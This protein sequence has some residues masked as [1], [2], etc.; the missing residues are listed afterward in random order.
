MEGEIRGCVR[1][2]ALDGNGTAEV[3]HATLADEA[4]GAGEYPC[5]GIEQYHPIERSRVEGPCKQTR[6]IYS[7]SEVLSV[8]PGYKVLRAVRVIDLPFCMAVSDLLYHP[9]ILKRTV[10]NLDVASAV[11]C[12]ANGQ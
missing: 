8:Q 5:H 4:V 10:S 7:G 1:E 11:A 12:R 3:E 2:A 9:M 6:S